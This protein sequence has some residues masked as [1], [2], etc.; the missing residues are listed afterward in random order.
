M[1]EVPSSLSSEAV[2][3]ESLQCSIFD[4][5]VIPKIP[6]L[7]QPRSAEYTLESGF[8]AIRNELPFFFRSGIYP[9]YKEKV[10]LGYNG[11]LRLEPKK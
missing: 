3:I 8:D 2:C 7:L 11:S 4:K 6:C 9:A 10:S 5:I 1:G